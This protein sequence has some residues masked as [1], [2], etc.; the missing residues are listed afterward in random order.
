MSLKTKLRSVAVKPRVT[1]VSNWL[2]MGTLFRPFWQGLLNTLTVKSKVEVDGENSSLRVSLS[3]KVPLSVKV[4]VWIAKTVEAATAYRSG[5]A[6]SE[7]DGC[8]KLIQ[9]GGAN[10]VF[11]SI[12]VAVNWQSLLEIPSKLI[13]RAESV[14]L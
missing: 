10:K 4:F 5:Y 2:L 3:S 6:V 8:V 11:L 12:K 13:F 1:V 7:N 9:F 14:I